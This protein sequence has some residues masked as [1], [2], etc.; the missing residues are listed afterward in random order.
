MSTS[1]CHCAQSEAHPVDILENEHTVILRVLD[2]AETEMERL[3]GGTP[4]RQEFWRDYLDFLSTFADRCH[5][6]K[7]EDVLFAALEA[8]GMSSDFGPTSCMRME[9]AE[10]RGIRARLEEALTSDDTSTICHLILIGI[11]NLRLHIQKENEVLF[12]MAR[13]LLGADVVKTVR[14][15]FDEAEEGMGHG[16]HCR[17]LEL[18]DAL[19]AASA[20]A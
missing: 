17:Y 10:M 5:H 9:H 15:G 8:N 11:D 4:I 16:T 3:E 12:P 1:N 20:D 14:Q 19:C 13:D 18:A 2:A 6:G 7:E